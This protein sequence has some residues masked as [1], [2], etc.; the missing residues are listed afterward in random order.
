MR[1]GERASPL[2]HLAELRA[3]ILRSAVYAL[4]AMTG[5]WVCYHPIYRF[6]AGPILKAV[7]RIQGE[8]Q[9]TAFMEG[10]LVRA[11]V[12]LVG[13]LI[14]AMPFIYREIW[15]FLS[16]ALSRHERRVLWPLVP[17]SGLLFLGG[18]TLAYLMTEPS[19]VWMASMNPP[20]TV[21]RYR[22]NENLLL[23]LRFYL[24]F[25]L[26]FQLPLVLVILAVVGVVDSRLLARR[27]RE[28]SVLIFILAAIITPTWDLLTMTA[29]ALPMTLLYWGTIGVVKVIE[30]RRARRNDE[31]SLAG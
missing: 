21:A 20:D 25:G 2:D 19:I 7:E 4:V 23:I 1:H 9:V 11:Q 6:I 5:V 15:C 30:R 8:I 27:W 26:A 10:F 13:G 18:V 22:L 3:R 29:C 31:Q 14:I 16:P 24:A 17:V 28:A 12:S